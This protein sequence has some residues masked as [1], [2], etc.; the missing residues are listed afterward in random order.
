MSLAQKIADERRARLAAEQRLELKQ[1]ELLALKQRWGVKSKELAGEVHN[2]RADYKS[3]IR[4]TRQIQTQFEAET[5]RADQAEQR[6]WSSIGA[7]RDGFAFFNAEGVMIAAN[8]NYLAYFNESGAV[9]PGAHFLDILA[10]AFDG[11]IIDPEGEDPTT[12]HNDLLENL[13]DEITEPL[14]LKLWNGRYVKKILQT[15]ETGDLVSLIL[16]VTDAVTYENT[17]ER[18][19]EAAEAA[20]R[21]KSAF[22]SN[23][24]HEIRTPMNGLVGMAD[25]LMETDL[26]EEQHLFASTIKSSGEALMAVIND[27][28]DY[29]RMGAGNLALRNEPFDLERCIHEVIAMLQIPAR[30]RGLELLVDYD[31]FMPTEFVGDPARVRQV[32]TKLIENA[33]KFTREGHVL[34]RVVGVIVK[35]GAESVLHITVQDTGIG[36]AEDRLEHIFGEFTQ[37]DDAQS[38]EFEGTG[39]GLAITRQLI[40]RMGGEIWVDSTEGEGTS[41]GFRLALPVHENCEQIPTPLPRHVENIVVASDISINCDLLKKQLEQLG[42]RVTLCGDIAETVK[43]ATQT[44]LVLIDHGA[45]NLDALELATELQGRQI[46]APVILMTS[47]ESVRSKA[48]E[49]AVVRAVIRKPIS[50]N[51]L[52]RSIEETVGTALPAAATEP[53][54]EKRRMR[55]LSAEDNKTNRL[56]LKKLLRPLEIDLEFAFNGLEAVEKYG[57]Y[58][59]DLI[60]MDI[61]MP[62][63]DGKEATRQIRQLEQDLDKHTP[64]VALTALAGSGDEEDIRAAGLDEYLTKP[65]RRAEVFG[66]ISGARPED[67]ANPFLGEDSDN[68]LVQLSG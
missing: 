3:V 45:G 19:H 16:D 54:I 52:C 37:A 65:V 49:M 64:I 27:V 21:A 28:L 10:F 1:A 13:H 57:Q 30:E 8:P 51:A 33:I 55:V 36:I 5:D 53:G 40:N 68:Q 61:S 35:E 47:D 24:S 44:D 14:V 38:R 50:R 59:P 25:L 56:V 4:K 60:L 62:Q 26:S 9:K 20:K 11:G 7:V 42:A 15:T 46:T 29:S 66:V 63:M 48:A 18:A 58:Q 43:C 67:A 34:V 6:L 17:L 2:A 32:L 22:L 39:L 12:L 41:F 23:M 31:L